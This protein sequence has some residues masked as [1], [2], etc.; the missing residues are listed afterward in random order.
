MK[1]N[2]QNIDREIKTCNKLAKYYHKYKLLNK[3]YYFVMCDFHF[4]DYCFPGS[5]MSK[6]EI[7]EYKLK[8][9]VK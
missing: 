6:E 9:I 1:C 2:M 3:I 7:I 5:A 4:K 8:Y